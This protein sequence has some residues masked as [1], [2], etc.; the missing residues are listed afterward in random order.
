MEVD[1]CGVR[2]NLARR[3]RALVAA[4]V[5]SC[6]CSVRGDGVGSRHMAA[7]QSQRFGKTVQ[8]VWDLSQRDGIRLPRGWNGRRRS[9]VRGGGGARALDVGRVRAACPPANTEAAVAP[10]AVA[11]A[12]CVLG[13]AA[14]SLPSAQCRVP[15]TES[16]EEGVPLPGFP[17]SCMDVSG[18]YA[19]PGMGSRTARAEGELGKGWAAASS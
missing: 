11:G 4:W 15:S 17:T 6:P 18:V 16:S 10:G 19:A 7:S 14:R 13:R 8:H 12:R 1:R 9:G 2:R 5:T 3:G